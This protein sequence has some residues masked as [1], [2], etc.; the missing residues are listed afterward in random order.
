MTWVVA[1]PLPAASLFGGV[2]YILTFESYRGALRPV[3]V[4][5]ADVGI[6]YADVIW[7]VG[8]S[9]FFLCC[10]VFG[11][12]A[13]STRIRCVRLS[14][15]KWTAGWV[16]GS[17]VAIVAL[18]SGL[19]L[20]EE[21]QYRDSVRAGETYDPFFTSRLQVLAALRA[22]LVRA[23]WT[24]S[25][26]SRPSLPAG[27]LLFL[28]AADGSTILYSPAEGTTLRV[29]SGDIVLTQIGKGR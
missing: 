19:A 27:D 28:G 23:E 9:L 5:P 17:A 11:I 16:I 13:L 6:G 15:R 1:N 12:L 26:A 4:T 29:P 8:Q 3:G 24:D 18:L 20:S 7:P 21:Q 22:N 2:L 10:V 25:E 14:L